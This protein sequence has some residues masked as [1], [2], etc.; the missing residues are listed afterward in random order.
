[1]ILAPWFVA[2]TQCILA[3]TAYGESQAGT[4]ITNTAMLKVRGA[5]GEWV[6]QSNPVALLVAERLDVALA[7]VDDSLI[8]V[9]SSGVAVP[10]LLTNRGNGRE[11]FEIA[12]LLSD[13]SARVRL[14]AIDRDGDGRFDPAIDT[15][16]TDARTPL[17]DPGQ[18]I[19]LLVVVDP[20][21]AEVTVAALTVT[22]RA[23]TGSGPEGTMFA[24]RGDGGSDAITGVTDARAEIAVPIGAAGSAVPMLV[25]SQS[26]RAPDGS[27]NP[28]AGAIITYRLEARFAG[29]AIAVRIDDPIPQGTAYVPGSLRLDEAVLSDAE[30]DDAGSADAAAIAVALGDIAA[31]ITR[32]VQFQVSIQ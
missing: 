16:L 15:P 23:A 10:V 22:A 12:A 7:R 2:L 29:P 19:R 4:L 6:L 21:A 13:A 24:A 5:E 32:T 11:S 25:K 1:M 9:P 26:V 30:G 3:S 31:P 8:E 27:S 14:I 17:L 18:A 28:V 20:V